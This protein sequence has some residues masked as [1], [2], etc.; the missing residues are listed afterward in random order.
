M[1]Y[2]YKQAYEIETKGICFF[3]A[4]QDAAIKFID[5]TDTETAVIPLCRPQMAILD[6]EKVNLQSSVLKKRGHGSFTHEVREGT[7]QQPLRTT[8]Q[9]RQNGTRAAARLG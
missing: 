1:R 8:T 3:N 6:F 2:L 7:R 5:Q 4:L 9:K